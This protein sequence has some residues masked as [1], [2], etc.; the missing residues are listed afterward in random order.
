MKSSTGARILL[1]IGFL[2]A[3]FAYTAWIA[4]RTAFN[5]DATQRAAHTLLTTDAVQKDLR[6]QLGTQVA[7]ELHQTNVDPRV[8]AAAT[9]A[10]RDPRVVGAFAT[11]VADTHRALLDNVDGT[12]TLDTSAVT[13]AVQDALAARD[14]KLAARLSQQPQSLE[15]KLDAK[16]LPQLGKAR[17]AARTVMWLGALAALFLIGASLLLDHDRRAVARAGRR[18]AYL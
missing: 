12:V 6:E 3:S 8:K 17:D 4:T 11:A 18:I 13:E 16:S 15:L 7:K 14:P 2:A 9:E 10:L 5:P 1:A